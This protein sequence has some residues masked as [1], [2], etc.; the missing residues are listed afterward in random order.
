[1]PTSSAFLREAT[2]KKVKY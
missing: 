1:M 2:T